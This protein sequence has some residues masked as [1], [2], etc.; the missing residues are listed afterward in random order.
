VPLDQLGKT[1]GPFLTDDRGL[2][3]GQLLVDDPRR[4]QVLA[5][6]GA[7]PAHQVFQLPDIPGP[8]M[9]FETL[10]GAAVYGLGRETLPI[11]PQKEGS[12]KVGNVF[13]P[14][15]ERRKAQGR[16]IQPEEQVFPEQPLLDETPSSP[17][18]S[19]R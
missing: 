8:G 1:S 14:I 17:D 9:G 2:M 15:P 3:L 10:K 12:G 18:W 7:N 19:R 11:G 5:I 13:G 16:D 6:E 4:N